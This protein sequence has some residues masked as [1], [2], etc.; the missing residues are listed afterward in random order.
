MT[1]NIKVVLPPPTVRALTEQQIEAVTGYL[2]GDRD[3]L[4]LTVDL[5]PVLKNLAEL[6]RVYFG[7]LVAGIQGRDQP[8]FARF[9]AD[10]AA[11]L[12]DLRNGRAPRCPGCRSPR[13]RP[14]APPTSSSGR[15]RSGSGRRCARRSRRR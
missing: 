1:S 8:D 2:R 7:D 12:D 6:A 11:A 5:D 13:T 3:E 15:S 4:R 9:T 10:L 14:T